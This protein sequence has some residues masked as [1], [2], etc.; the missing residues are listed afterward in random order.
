MSLP[1]SFRPAI[2]PSLYQLMPS[3]PARYHDIAIHEESPAQ[4]IGAGQHDLPR[5]FDLHD[6]VAQRSSR[7]LILYRLAD[8]L[9]Q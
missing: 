6:F 5:L 4:E 3:R 2:L 8:L 7:R 1:I 9:A